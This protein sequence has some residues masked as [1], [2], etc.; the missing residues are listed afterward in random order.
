MGYGKYKKYLLILSTFYKS[1]LSIMKMIL[2]MI[3]KIKRLNL[4]IQN[5]IKDKME[6]KIDFI[7]LV[8]VLHMFIT[9]GRRD[10]FLTF[11]KKHLNRNGRCLLCVL[12]ME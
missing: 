8:A 5:L 6:E 12:V 11:I 3:F 9:Q 4:I 10:K 2:S 7:Y 1:K